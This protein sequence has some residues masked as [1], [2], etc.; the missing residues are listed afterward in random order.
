MIRDELMVGHTRANLHIW[1]AGERKVDPA[2]ELHETI[3]DRL[4]M[5]TVRN[6]TGFGPYRPKVLSEHPKAKGYYGN[7]T[8]QQTTISPAHS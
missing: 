1:P 5:P 2:G 8:N 3:I 4:K 6:F 7:V